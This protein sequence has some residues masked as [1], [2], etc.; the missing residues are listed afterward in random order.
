ML[1]QS[2]HFPGLMVAT[3]PG[4]VALILAQREGV[5]LHSSA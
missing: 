1:K 2:Y 3:V 4:K 5:R